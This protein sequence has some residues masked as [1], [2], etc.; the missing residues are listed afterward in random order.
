M[1]L[2]NTFFVAASLAVLA[3][4]SCRQHPGE[5]VSRDILYYSAT[6]IDTEGYVFFKSVHAKVV[7]ETQ[8]AKEVQSAQASPKAK[9]I[10]AKVIDTYQG[11][12]SDLESYAR[13]HYVVLPDAATPPFSV[14]HH[15]H[16]DSLGSF[17]S[18]AYIAHVQH[19]QEG[20][21]EQFGRAERNTAKSLRSYAKEKLPAVRELFVLAGGQEDQGAHH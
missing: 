11:V 2:R 19:E 9:E 14:P 12:A 17:N 20:I 21:L 10:A 7:Q 5:S 3:F 15:F 1:K 16:P 6:R 13:E 18:E 8:L 4:G